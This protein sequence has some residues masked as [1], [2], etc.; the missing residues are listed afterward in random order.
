MNAAL[1]SFA[2]RWVGTPFAYDGRDAAGID[3]WGLVRTY[4][5]EV[6]GRTL[7]DWSKG[8]ESDLWVADTITENAPSVV[9]PLA[10]P[11]DGCIVLAHAKGRAHHVGVYLAGRVL[12]ADRKRG[13]VADPIALFSRVYR[14]LTYG[15]LL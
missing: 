15:R 14:S 1:A 12:H 9:E 11:Q 10:A 6:A 13:V 2:D 8:D 3:C 5:V 7:P 4:A